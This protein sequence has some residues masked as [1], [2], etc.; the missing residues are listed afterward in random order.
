MKIMEYI[1]KYNIVQLTMGEILFKLLI[2]KLVIDTR[3]TSMLMSN[4]L[5]L[6]GTYISN[7]KSD[8]SKFNQYMKLNIT[9]LQSH[10]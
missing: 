7:V 4:N 2:Q 1:H 9:K 10:G 5:S 3:E 6:L 8:M